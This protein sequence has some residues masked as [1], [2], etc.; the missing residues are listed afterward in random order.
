MSAARKLRRAHAKASTTP[1]ARRRSE[2]LE[3]RRVEVLRL[4][5]ELNY[6][7]PATAQAPAWC[8]PFT[9]RVLSKN[10]PAVTTTDEMIQVRDDLERW[11]DQLNEAA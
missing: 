10:G 7:L 6:R 1:A 2:E 4:M 3:A 5:G 9:R 8:S 11:R